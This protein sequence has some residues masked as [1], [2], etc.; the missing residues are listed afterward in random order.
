MRSSRPSSSRGTGH[1]QHPDQHEQHR[2][3]RVAGGA[4]ETA[5]AAAARSAPPRRCPGS[6]ARRSRG[7][8]SPSGP[9]RPRAGPWTRPPC[10]GPC[11]TAARRR[12]PARRGSGAGPGGRS[13]G[14]VQG[15]T[16]RSS[17]SGAGPGRRR[18]GEPV[19]APLGG[20]RVARPGLRGPGSGRRPPRSGRVGRVGPD[21]RVRV[22]R[23]RVETGDD[24]LPGPLL[25]GVGQPVR[26]LV[27][28]GRRHRPGPERGLGV[29]DHPALPALVAVD[30]EPVGRRRGQRQ[31]PGVGLDVRG[32]LQVGRH[33]GGREHVQQVLAHPRV[34]VEQRHERGRV[35]AVVPPPPPAARWS[36]KSAP[37][38]G[39]EVW[40]YGRTPGCRRRSPARRSRG[41]RRGRTLLEDHLGDLASR[42]R[43]PAPPPT[44]ARRRGRPGDG[45]SSTG[46][47]TRPRSARTTGQA[48]TA[49]PAP[50]PGSGRSR[51]PSTSG[52]AMSPAIAG[53]DGHDQASAPAANFTSLRTVRPTG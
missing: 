22:D 24:R 26:G 29:N 43:R 4:R 11:R 9:P 41:W 28:A 5:G 37:A 27:V 40:R 53:S 48:A 44:S 30:P 12:R 23:R 10:P 1:E 33:T 32:R 49:S 51:A 21:R 15:S 50:A 39:A 7:P 25:L 47:V 19:P 35:Q 31:R 52:L 16:M 17:R 18:L 6:A 36:C 8:R 2:E 42:R 3:H 46:A 20:P 14:R 38:A 34:D 45:S 13:P